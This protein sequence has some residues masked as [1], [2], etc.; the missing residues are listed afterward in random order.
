MKDARHR[1]SVPAAPGSRVTKS[2]SLEVRD[3]QMVLA[4]AVGCGSSSRKPHDCA[5][6]TVR[7]VTDGEVPELPPAPGINRRPPFDAAPKPD[8]KHFLSAAHPTMCS[9]LSRSL[10]DKWAFFAWL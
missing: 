6:D 10:A 7:T 3:V 2:A 5:R 1:R 8:R 4:G 9:G